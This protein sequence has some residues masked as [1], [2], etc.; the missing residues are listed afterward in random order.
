MLAVW[1]L[2]GRAATVL[3]TDLMPGAQGLSKGKSPTNIK[4]VSWHDLNIVDWNVKLI[5]LHQSGMMLCVH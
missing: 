3:K 4:A 5:F 1:C 2:H